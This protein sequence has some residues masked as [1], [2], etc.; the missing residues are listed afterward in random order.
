MAW[1]RV[2][3]T[4]SYSSS[5]SSSSSSSVRHT[6][7][8]FFACR[9]VPCQIHAAMTLL[10]RLHRCGRM[11]KMTHTV[12]ESEMKRSE[13]R[14]RETG[15]VEFNRGKVNTR[16]RC[17]CLRIMYGVQ[18]R[19]DRNAIGKMQ[20]ENCGWSCTRYMHDGSGCVWSEELTVEAMYHVRTV[21]FGSLISQA[22]Q[23]ELCCC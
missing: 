21:E 18:Q 8:C 1:Y 17:S 5:S 15:R 9:A 6:A 19:C 12:K 7:I 4:N 13:A 2:V 23:A 3:Y 16:G 20:V 22:V 11:E 14:D 10:T